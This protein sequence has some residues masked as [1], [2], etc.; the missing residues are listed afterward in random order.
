MGC[1]LSAIG[2]GLLITLT[3]N[4]SAAMWAGFQIV[5][6]I[7]RG[8]TMRQGITAIQAALPPAMLP[9]GSAYVMFIQLIGGTLFISFGQTLFTN[10]LKAGLNHFAPTV[11]VEKILAVG[12]TAF[13][14]VVTAKEVPG[15]LLAYNQALTKVY[16]S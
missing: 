14:T 9:V 4:S 11:D 8:L 12:A 5:T 13:R 2:A 1:A 10:Q 16:V 7:G 3:P 6:G 15:V